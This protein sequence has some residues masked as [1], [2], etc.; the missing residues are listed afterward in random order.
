M[1][2][3]CVDPPGKT[4]ALVETLS[5]AFSV[6]SDPSLEV[7][8]KYGV[9][10][11][12]NGIAWPGVFIIRRDGIVGWRSISKTY[13]KRPSAGDLLDQLDAL[14]GKARDEPEPP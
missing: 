10:D 3:V 8:G 13:K 14:A 9:V 6:L 2:A 4:R 11:E 5:L 1:A 7:A 12:E